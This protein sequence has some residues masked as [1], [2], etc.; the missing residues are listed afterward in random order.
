MNKGISITPSVRSNND[1]SKHNESKGPLSL[2]DSDLNE[3]LQEYYWYTFQLVQKQVPR[4]CIL[5]EELADEV[6]DLTQAT[7]IRFWPKLISKNDLLI[8]PKAYIRCIVHSQCV[9]L[10]RQRK[11]KQTFPFPL[12]QDGELYQGRALLMPSSDM[13]DPALEY[14]R[15]ELITEV[16]EDVVKLPPKQRNAMI[17]AL[18]EEVGGTFPLVEAFEKYGMAIENINWPSDPIEL[19]KLRSSL[20]AAQKK[21]RSLKRRYGFV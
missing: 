4:N 5:P 9:D 3:S 13:L 8:S 17:C 16:I 21:L 19:H 7:L 1:R 11:R 10:V 18:K 20:L 14:E 6:H 2:D 15:K 12:D